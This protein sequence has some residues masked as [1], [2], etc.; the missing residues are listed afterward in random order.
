[1]ALK[2]NR[3]LASPLPPE[4]DTIPKSFWHRVQEWD[5][6]TAMRQKDFGIWKDTSWRTYGQKAKCLGLGLVKLGLERGD[7]VAIISKTIPNGCLPTWVRC[8]WVV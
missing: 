8:V 4:V 1:M 5:N 7:R 3:K 6:R 2:G